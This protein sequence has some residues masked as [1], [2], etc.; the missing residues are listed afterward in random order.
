M[1]WLTRDILNEAFVRYRIKPKDKEIPSFITTDS[2]EIVESSLTDTA[3]SSV[4]K[5]EILVDLC[6]LNKIEQIHSE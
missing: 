3:N 1:S 5:S 2:L 4:E 6:W